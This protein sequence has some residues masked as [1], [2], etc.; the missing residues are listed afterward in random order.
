MQ[1]AAFALFFALLIAN[2]Q[3]LDPHAAAAVFFRFDPL[4][5]I[6]TMIAAGTWISYLAPA[7]VTIV[8]TLLLGRVWCG[9]ICPLGT[10]LGWIR[11]PTASRLSKRM[12]ARLPS[13]KYVLLGSIVILAIYGSLALLIL[14]PLTLLTRSAVTSLLP[15]FD[16]VVGRVDFLQ[17][18]LQGSAVPLS[19]PRYEQALA[20]FLLLLGVVLLNILADRFWCRFL[21]P[22]GALL[23]LLAKVQFVRPIVGEACG[24]CGACA[25]SCR[26]DAIE[27]LGRSATV[28]TASAPAS[29][30]FAPA[31]VVSAE[32]T[33]C[34]DC[35]AT[36]PTPE[37]M[38]IGRS[39]APTPITR[40]DPSRR[41]FL[42][43]SAL[44]VGALLGLGGALLSAAPPATAATRPRLIRPP[45]AQ[46]EEEFLSRCLRC[47]ECL[48]VCPTSGLQPALGQGGL[49]ALWTPVLVPRLGYCEY[50]C[51]A[52]GS[53]CPSGA[54]PELDLESKQ[55]QMLGLARIDQE[56]C[57]PWA[58]D[59]PCTVCEEV[60]PIP[61]KAIVLREPR[62]VTRPD[63]TQDY[64][65]LPSVVRERCTGCGICE[66]HCP[67][68]GT[69]AI[70][71]RRRGQ[72][73]GRGPNPARRRREADI[74]DRP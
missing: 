18:N 36:C 32:C 20:L 48:L 70:T 56:R 52:C 9:W 10:L 54:I 26:L 68:E 34:L 46:R 16:W 14:D 73:G 67:V 72:G 65:A 29:L 69:A 61:E 63:G 4:T 39:H 1:F 3:R 62:L 49:E 45:G 43:V 23:G 33:M 31:R 11:F 51:T 35:L 59:T 58:L 17:A 13:V 7:L 30:P 64:I 40:H 15:A 19:Q 27:R 42:T 37:A 6:A 66:Y 22:L 28:E 8:A 60:C 25:R 71:V 5:S 50:S 12:P 44:G 57:L 47:G 53:V 74:R 41:E 24:S 38:H 55:A 21:C 2:Q